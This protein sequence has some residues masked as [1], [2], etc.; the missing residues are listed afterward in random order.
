M[1]NPQYS[2]KQFN[3]LSNQLYHALDKNDYEAVANIANEQKKLIKK[4]SNS[5][6]VATQEISDRWNSALREFQV[7]RK[8]LQSDLK[9]L[10]NHTRNNLRRLKG[11]SS[12]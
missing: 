11:Y 6:F 12:K 5:N 9:K 3:Y 4:F 8:H 7:L 2:L 10:N 1:R